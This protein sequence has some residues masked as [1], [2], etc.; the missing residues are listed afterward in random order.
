MITWDYHVILRICGFPFVEIGIVSR[1]SSMDAT[2]TIQ[3]EGTPMPAWGN[4]ALA[5]APG[6]MM[7]SPTALL[8]TFDRR[9]PNIFGRRARVNPWCTQK[10]NLTPL[11]A[12]HVPRM[13]LH[14]WFSKVP[15]STVQYLPFPS[16]FAF[17]IDLF[18]LVYHCTELLEAL[19]PWIVMI[20]LSSLL[21]CTL[22]DEIQP[23][24][25][26]VKAGE[27]LLFGLLY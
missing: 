24:Q 10:P 1:P 2:S 5:A 9:R 18:L 19:S 3:G 16:I 27:L 22:C 13:P 8:A 12:L 26:R 6:V 15:L 4:D 17:E 7:S 23:K 25:E 14:R 20:V 21:S 11:I